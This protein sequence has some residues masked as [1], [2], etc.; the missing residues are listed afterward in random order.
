[1]EINI[2]RIKA[3]TK[4]QEIFGIAHF[5]DEQWAAIEKILKGER[6]LMIQKTGFGKS[7]CYQFPATLFPG[8]TVIFS[9]LV[10]LMRD[11]V[12]GLKKR[13]IAA[14]F[15]NSEQTPEENEKTIKAAKEGWLKILY[16]A[17]ERQENQKWIEAT[18]N[19]QLSMIVIDEAHTISTWGHDF[20]PAFR[21]IIQLVNLLP[22]HL[23]IL[24]TTATATVKVQRDIEK[25]IGGKL[26]TIR[27]SLI[28]KNF[29]LYVVKVKSEDEKYLWIAQNIAK[30]PGSGLI[31]TG[32]RVDTELYSKWL[33]HLGVPAM[34]YHA[35][36]DSDSRKAIERGLMTNSWKAIVSTN[37]LGMG[38]DKPDIRFVIH[39]QIPVSPVHYY[40][41]IG[42]AGRD[43]KPTFIILLYN[44]AP[45]KEGLPTDHRLPK[46]FI[47]NARPTVS[48]YEKVISEIRKE[49]LGEREIIKLA[50][51]KTPQFRTIKADLMEQGIMREVKYGNTKRYEYIPNSPALDFS[52]FES[53][54]KSK[55]KEFEKM[56]GYIETKKP[57]MQYLCEF[58]DDTEIKIGNLRCDNTGLSPLHCVPD[59]ILESQLGEFHANLFP[60]IEVADS[61]SS[62]I[63]G[64]SY[65]IKS[66]FPAQYLLF[67]NKELI[68]TV[69]GN[70]IRIPKPCECNEEQL[71]TLVKKHFKSKSRLSDGYASAYYGMSGVG[72]ALH[73]SKYEHGGDFPDFLLANCLR[74]IRKKYKNIKFDLICYIP[75]TLSGDLVRNFATKIGIALGIEI[76]HDL[77]KNRDTKEQKVFQSTFSKQE[78]I[79][80]AF[81]FKNPDI[82][83][84]KTILLIDDIYD[85]GTTLKEAGRVLTACGAKWIVPLVIAKTVGGTL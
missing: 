37:A 17:P 62:R 21:K 9:P 26:T 44:G 3:E 81:K 39:T 27:G 46:S 20:R 75:P 45:D 58:L 70:K 61:S 48:R 40:Q 55:L 23:P 32:T 5:Y 72:N 65:S 14:G 54:R 18:R 15:I 28:R 80:G 42:R 83:A 38:I 64:N 36:L 76:S 25:Q 43:G 7:L 13:G 66:Q 51:L 56:V 49:P 11:Q 59:P 73:R 16:I 47:E 74:L 2:D 19:L 53:L 82:L 34:E 33:Q 71:M 4:L 69:I 8:I 35:G 50:N 68:G 67:E 22:A 41:E 12:K 10:A 77:I 1:M 79:K 78:N 52:G 29:R 31:Y 63:G 85:S 57:R 60:V 30:L 24:A 84:D 6:I